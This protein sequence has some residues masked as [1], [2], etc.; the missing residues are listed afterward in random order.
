V[1][2]QGHIVDVDGDGDLDMVLHFNTQD[3]GIKAGDTE[4]SL[5]G[6][7]IDGKSIRGSDAIVTVPSKGKPAPAKQNRVDSRGKLSTFWGKI[8]V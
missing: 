4:A 3:T 8:K 2:K 5:T 1:H 7:T 6:K